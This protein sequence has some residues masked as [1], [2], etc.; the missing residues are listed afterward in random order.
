MTEI[1]I[2]QLEQWLQENKT[3]ELARRYRGCE[4][5]EMQGGA[6]LNV[7]NHHLE[8]LRNTAALVARIYGECPHQMEDNPFDHVLRCR[9]CS[10][11]EGEGWSNTLN[12]WLE[13]FSADRQSVVSSLTEPLSKTI[14]RRIT[15]EIAKIIQKGESHGTEKINHPGL[16]GQ[17]GSPV[18]G[19]ESDSGVYSQPSDQPGDH[20]GAGHGELAPVSSAQGGSETGSYPTSDYSG[21]GGC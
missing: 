19:D 14:K 4:I 18:G 13:K 11:A 6:I 10:W 12:Q 5:Q 15:N 8:G 7:L 21:G 2:A 17:V 1:S 3:H 9:F 16:A 20:V